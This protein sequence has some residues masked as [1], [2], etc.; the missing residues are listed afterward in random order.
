MEYFC[1]NEI[2]DVKL[3]SY[4]ICIEE[5]LENLVKFYFYDNVINVFFRLVN[6]V[7]LIDI[8]KLFEFEFY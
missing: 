2:N 1:I 7:I 6:G 5:V 4:V 3:F 8:I